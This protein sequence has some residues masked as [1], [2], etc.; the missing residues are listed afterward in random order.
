MVFG[1][2]LA[3]RASPRRVL[4]IVVLQVASALLLGCG[5][6]V[7]RTGLGRLIDTSGHAIDTRAVVIVFAFLL[8][9]GFS[10]GVIALTIGAE[11]TMLRYAVER[12]ATQRLAAA[13]AA[14]SLAEFEDP[15]FHDRVERSTT[16]ARAHAPMLLTMLV[17]AL[18]VVMTL[19]AVTT[20]LFIMAWWLAFLLAVAMVPAAGVALSRQRAQY[21]L[22]VEMTGNQRSRWYLLRL[23][24]GREEAKEIRAYNLAG[25]FLDRLAACY[26]ELLTKQGALQR[27]YVLLGIGARLVG[28][29]VVA[30]TVA[31]VIIATST[32]YLDTAATLT[33]LGGLYLGAQQTT[34]MASLFAFTGTSLHYLQDLRGFT[35]PAP[36]P[37]GPAPDG[38]PFTMLEARQVTFAYPAGQQP[39]LRQVSVSLRAGEVVALVG[40]NGSGKTTLAK[41]LTGL[42]LP[43]SGHI[44]VD[45]RTVDDPAELKGSSAVLFQDYLRYKFTA[46]E[47]ITL[48][49]PEAAQDTSRLTRAADQAG[50]AGIVAS[51]PHGFDTQLGADFAGGTD[52]SIGQW[53]RIALARVFFRDSQFVVLD[54]PTAAMDPR[55][56]A[57]LFSRTRELFA[58]RTVL[59][60]SHRFSSVRTADRIYVMRHGRVIEEGTHQTL[61]ARGGMYAEMFTTQAAAYLY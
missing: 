6:L 54:E 61:M 30:A 17:I 9:V 57:A 53:Q 41:L 12:D 34:A 39:A 18:R 44:T 33:A 26:C 4:T 36:P 20:A 29:A 37:P 49:R 2:R 19:L 45:G 60:I 35:E 58:G 40:D 32:G 38:K 3:W 25:T 47:N 5:L 14:S 10:S 8:A 48:G 27:R 56:E 55:A 31:A 50:A 16:A 59:L 46:G 24:T 13:A 42:Y 51:L 23:L 7:A 1:L 28:D 21:A 22:Q 15:T 43:D 52:L 11:E